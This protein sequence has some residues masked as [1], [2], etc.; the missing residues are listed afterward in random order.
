MR[1]RHVRSGSC[2]RRLF[3][4]A[5]PATLIVGSAHGEVRSLDIGIRLGWTGVELTH[6]VGAEDKEDDFLAHYLPLIMYPL[7]HPFAFIECACHVVG[8]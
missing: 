2:I 5:P 8:F 6:N 4:S 7:F 1:V 3:S